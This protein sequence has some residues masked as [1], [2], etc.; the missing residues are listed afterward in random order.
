MCG[1]V[2]Y[3]GPRQATEVLIDGLRR[4][5]YRG[6]DSSGIAVAHH[7]DVDLRRRVGKVDSL[8]E[9]LEREPISGH[10]GIAHTRWATHGQPSEENAHPHTDRREQLFLVH[11]GIIENYRE[12]RHELER[13]GCTFRSA[14]D[15]EVA[16]QLIGKYYQGDPVA[17]LRQAIPRLRGSFAFAIVFRDHPDRLLVVRNRSPLILGVG[18]GENFIGSDPQALLRY[19]RRV[20]FLDDEEMAQITAD[21]VQVWDLAGN[22]KR[23]EPVELSYEAAAAELGSYSHFMLKEIHEQPSVLRGLL[24]RYVS[25]DGTRVCFPDLGL[26][27]RD[28]VDVRRIFIQACGTSWHA[29]LLGK[30]L[31]ER[32]ARIP[33]D[34]DISS[35]FR[36]SDTVLE[37]NTLVIGISGSPTASS[38]R[39]R[40]RRS[41]SRARRPTRR[42]SPASTCWRS[43]WARS[44]GMWTRSAWPAA[45]VASPPS[46]T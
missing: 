29:G 4:L 17:A 24:E 9:S 20:L 3:I 2:G 27:P 18:D 40:D 5:E 23:K 45:S 38:T 46:R 42:R 11:N 22:E 34:T 13:E 21:G 43:T 41:A 28:L 31:I 1:I 16:A 37:P 6:Y 44:A 39:P 19:T 30:M 26:H 14:T 7:G 35:E 25:P 15:T 10:I 8:A 32:V 36:Y 33:V 12:L